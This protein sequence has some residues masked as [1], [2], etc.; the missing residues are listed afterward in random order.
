[1]IKSNE[2]LSL[3]QTGHASRP[4]MRTGKHF[5]EIG[6]TITSSEAKPP[7]FPKIA[8][9]DRYF[10]SRIAQKLFNRCSRDSVNRWQHMGEGR[11][12]WIIFCGN[13]DHVTLGSGLGTVEDARR[14][15][16]ARDRG[17][18]IRRQWVRFTRRLLIIF[19]HQHKR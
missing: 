13:P 17:L 3:T 11:N 6:C 5:T 19:I 4:Y 7:I 18:Y 1:M 15:L 12:Q 2:R 10:V 14:T 16:P 8:L 9:N